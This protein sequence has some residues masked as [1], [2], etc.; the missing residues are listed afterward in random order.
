MEVNKQIVGSTQTHHNDSLSVWS[1]NKKIIVIVKLLWHLSTE[2]K[3]ATK[4]SL[5]IENQA[6]AHTFCIMSVNE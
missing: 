4:R 1:C 6:F 5:L 2:F 3:E